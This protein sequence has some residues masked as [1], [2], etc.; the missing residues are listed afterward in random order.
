MAEIIITEKEIINEEGQHRYDGS[1]RG[2]DFKLRVDDK[3]DEKWVV[4][5]EGEDDFSDKD[6]ETISEQL[7]G[8]TY[9]N[10]IEEAGENKVC[11]NNNYESWWSFTYEVR[12]TV[13]GEPFLMEWVEDDNGNDSDIKLGSELFEGVEDIW[14]EFGDAMDEF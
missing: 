6:K 4:Y 11:V 12:G 14:D 3:N 9:V 8:M 10:T 7:I 13:N 1:Y 2:N 5:L